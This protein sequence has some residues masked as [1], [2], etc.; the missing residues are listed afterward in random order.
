M[1]YI[2]KLEKQES[3][4][5]FF[6]LKEGGMRRLLIASL[7]LI[8][9]ANAFTFGT[10]LE[11][12]VVDTRVSEGYSV[13]EVLTNVNNYVS[14][15]S[16][17][18]ASGIYLQNRAPFDIQSDV[19]IRGSRFSQVSFAL[20]GVSFNDIQTGHLN[21]SLPFTVYD[22]DSVSI[23]KSGNSTIYGSD[24]IGGVI[25][26]DISKE[27]IEGVNIR[28]YVGGYGL[29][30]STFSVSKGFGVLGFRLS[31]DKK[32]SDGWK[33]NTDFDQWI[34]N[35]T[36]V[37][38]LF[39]GE[40][41]LFV[42]H[43]EKKYGASLFY[44]TEARESE[45]GTLGIASFGFG[46]FKVNLLAKSAIDNY[47]VNISS[48]T[49]QTNNHVKYQSVLSVEDT[50]DFGNYGSL[51]VR[52][53]GRGNVIDSKAYTTNGETNLLG[54]R[55][56]VPF[57]VVFEYGFSPIDKSSLS[58]GLR[59]DI[60]YLG[61]RVYGVV[62]SPS[63]KGY[64][65]IIDSI[66]VSGSA[67]RFFRVPTYI[68]LYY[69]DGIAF[70]NTNLKPEEGWNYELNLFYFLNEEQSSYLFVSG[71]WRDALNVIDFADDRSIPGLRFEAQNIRWISGGG[72]EVGLNFSHN[73]LEG[74]LLKVF[75]SYSKFDS[76]VPDNYTFRYDKYLEH[77]ANLVIYQNLYGF[78]IYTLVSFRN[79]FEGKDANGNL[80]PYTTYTLI[81]AKVSY[82]LLSGV[83]LFVE[84]ENL[85]DV[86][87]EDINKVKMPRRWIWG[88]IEVK[89]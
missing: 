53:E 19:S 55:Y 20:G 31:F 83:K 67:S 41:V 45:V 4:L 14:F 71:Y 13:V 62:T 12:Y 77:Q 28:S 25:N 58:I 34:L 56:D 69:Y 29:F 16:L 89:F 37:S 8:L 75:Y 84:G 80:L 9:V 2:S 18:E 79:R 11:E 50:F 7:L 47:I 42:G 74:G 65:Y 23:Q 43:I 35:T 52:V 39:G 57:G 54:N 76:G 61:D 10:E 30:G 66:K 27:I 32:R 64:Y 60:W 6:L 73:L 72:V 46:K 1:L 40:F 48:P 85:G 36:F 26:F 33:F 22:I 70:G 21:L 38:K 24:A 15:R 49:T 51:F 86:E 81:N 87:Y 63:L 78:G 88:G 44:G 59:N 68:E 82:E 5:I 3:L 17:L